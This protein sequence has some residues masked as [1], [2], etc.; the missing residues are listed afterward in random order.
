M[1]KERKEETGVRT[2]IEEGCSIGG[3][4]YEQTE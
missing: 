2:D 4:M 1:Q 3:V